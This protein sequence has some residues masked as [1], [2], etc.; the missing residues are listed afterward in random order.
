[1]KYQE[2][3]CHRCGNKAAALRSSWFNTQMLCPTCSA[4]EACHP[5][6]EHAKRMEFF[7]NQTGDY[8]FVGI[9]LPDDLQS[10]YYAHRKY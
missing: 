4:E 2:Q 1:M 8:R 6:Y 9:G 7:K 5:L 3:N 10:K